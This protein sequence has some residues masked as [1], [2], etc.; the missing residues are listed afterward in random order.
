M[1]R[2]ATGL[3]LIA[4]YAAHAGADNPETLA[5]QSQATARA[6]LDRAIAALG[7]AQEL[8]AIESVKVRLEG[9]AWPRLQMS[10]PEPPFEDGKTYEDLLLD[11][12]GSRLRFEQ[13]QWTPGFE[14]PDT[15][16]I[17][18][19]EGMIYNHRSQTLRPFPAPPSIEQQFAQHYR[20]LP[21]LLLRQALERAGTLRSLGQEAFE[22][23]LHDVFTF[24]M[25]DGQQ[26]ALYVEKAS[27]L[28]SK[29]DLLIVDPLAG[30]DAAEFIFGDYVR[31]GR[32]QVPRSLRTQEAGEVTARAQVEIEINPAVSDS[33][34]EG[35]A[36][37]ARVGP[38]RFDKPELIERLA[39][40]V[41]V[42]QNVAGPMQN[43]LAVE[44][45]EYIVAVEAPG[46]IAGTER[47]IARIKATIPGKPVRYIA[48]TH[49]HGDHIGGLRSFIDEGATV[50]T[51]PG[52]R[53]VVAAV[54]AAAIAGRVVQRP[55]P[56]E[57]LLTQRGKRVLTDGSRTLE[58]IDIG[59][60]AHAREMLVAYLPRERV[61][62]QADLFIIPSNEASFGPPREPFVSFAQKLKQLRL[63]V[64]RIA[65]VH[66]RTA[67]IE[68]FHQRMSVPGPGTW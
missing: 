62:F 58:L 17:K 61:V 57:I 44:F 25:G 28:V 52:N 7:G 24:V 50:I 12:K 13:R 34:F 10:V 35:P 67:T 65:G 32:T 18:G 16:V 6:V 2:R 15:V 23:K 21:H 59:P 36:G 9:P 47:V 33:S 51:T 5:E 37:Y 3:L 46:S 68:E 39:D 1:L 40:G 14:N 20:R 56:P 22:G 38:S 53:K 42:I 11:M 27:G 60:N 64:D 49:H 31:S 26:P 8:Q 63:N 45:K 55:G 30:D 43:T 48:M 19:G 29:Y 54:A 66:G 41:F 4:A